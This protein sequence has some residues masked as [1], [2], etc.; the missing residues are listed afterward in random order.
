M[1]ETLGSMIQCLAHTKKNPLDY[2]H[3]DNLFITWDPWVG[4]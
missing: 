3:P 4:R 1:L 2:S